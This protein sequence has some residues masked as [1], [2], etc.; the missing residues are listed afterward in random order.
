[1]PIRFPAFLLPFFDWIQVE[2]TSDCNAACTYCPHT[3]YRVSWKNR[4]FSFEEFTRLTPLFSRTRHVHLQGWGEPF[5]HPQFFQMVRIAKEAGCHVGTT[6]NGMLLDADRIDRIIESNLDMI[7][8]SLAGTTEQTDRIRK[9]TQLSKI[10]EA[11]KK[12]SEKKA[13]R[14]SVKPEIHVAYMLLK[15]NLED[16]E[17]L[18]EILTGSGV[19]QVVVSTLDFIPSPEL[20]RE[21]LTP[22]T[23]AESHELVSRI[24]MVADKCASI[25]ISVH[26]YFHPAR[27]GTLFC[28]ENVEKAACIASNGDV[29]PCVFTNFNLFRDSY[30]T[31]IWI[32]PYPELV[33]GNVGIT[34]FFKIWKRDGY[35]RFRKSFGKESPPSSCK[36]CQ[37]LKS[38]V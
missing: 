38:G 24:E 23:F 32:P 17:N 37:K 13:K 26:H 4:Y 5:L 15:S 30:F 34:S 7:A 3:V 28:T 2:I 19:A 33:F 27:P 29:T 18:P 21:S 20:A 11:I 35:R 31:G 25:G 8:F 6:T 22:K 36:G 16:L 9:G 10:L 1:M 14:H 12:L